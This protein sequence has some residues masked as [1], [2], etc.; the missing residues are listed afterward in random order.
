VN[1]KKSFDLGSAHSVSGSRSG[2]SSVSSVFVPTEEGCIPAL[3][4]TVSAGALGSFSLVPAVIGSDGLCDSCVAS[5][6]SVDSSVSALG[7]YYASRGISPLP[8]VA[9]GIL[10]VP[11]GVDTLE[12]PVTAVARCSYWL[13]SVLQGVQDRLILTGM[14]FAV[15][16]LLS[17]WHLV[18]SARGAAY[19]LPITTD[20][21]N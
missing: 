20:Y 13:G 8:S 1:H 16:G 5:G 11:K 2:L 7:D 21:S 17:K 18:N 3:S 4:D 6:T 19:Q 9:H 12:G 15:C 14:G 10:V